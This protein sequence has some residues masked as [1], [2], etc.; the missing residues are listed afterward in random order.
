[1]S[2]QKNKDFFVH[3]LFPTSILEIENFIDKQGCKDILKKIK[4]NKKYL[5]K[6]LSLVGD[7]STTYLEQNFLSKLNPLIKSSLLEVTKKYSEMTGFEIENKFAGSWFNIQKK[8]SALKK[9]NHPMSIISGILYIQCDKDSFNTHFH[10]PNPMLT[11]TKINKDTEFSVD[12]VAFKP[13]VGT[14]LLFPS[15]LLHG[16]NFITNKC[17]QRIVISFN[18]T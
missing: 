12:W 18:V 15:W 14:L 2:F 3:K 7:A 6:H 10:N 1:M 8:N 13:K 11:F 17:D 4:Q 9:H 16:S 5:K